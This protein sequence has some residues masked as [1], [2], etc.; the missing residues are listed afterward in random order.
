MGCTGSKKPQNDV[1]S[2]SDIEVPLPPEELNM[3]EVK[4]YLNDLSTTKDLYNQS[5]LESYGLDSL[6]E[7]CREQLI[8][9]ATTQQKSKDNYEYLLNYVMQR[10][11]DDI[12]RALQSSNIDK[13]VLIEILTARPKW[14]LDRIAELYEKNHH[15]S[16]IGEIQK[17]LKKFSGSQSELGK[18]LLNVCMEQPQ[19]DSYL[20]NTHLK[21]LDII[22]EVS[23]LLL[24]FLIF[25]FSFYISRLLQL[26][27]IGNYVML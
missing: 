9:L 12:Y 24:F 19:R 15:T 1:L 26:V 6:L 23:F 25:F 3:N 27:P 4:K 14:Q 20:L 2:P 10:D 8:E 7:K 17:Q 13:R 21:E 16:L 11:S 22:I 5:L 18:L